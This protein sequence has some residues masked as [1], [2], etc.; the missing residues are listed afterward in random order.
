MLVETDTVDGARFG[1]GIGI[2]SGVHFGVFAK[3]ETSAESH[4]GTWSGHGASYDVSFF[5]TEALV[6]ILVGD[7]RRG[8][9]MPAFRAAA[10]YGE[11]AR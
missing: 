6:V 8:L 9:G 2:L 1:E 10:E 7:A 5:L 4:C 11:R 3:A